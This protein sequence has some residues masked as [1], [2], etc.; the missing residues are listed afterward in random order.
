MVSCS[1][2]RKVRIRRK[3]K[4]LLMMFWNLLKKFLNR[5]LL[6]SR[7]CLLNSPSELKLR[8]LSRKPM[9]LPL[10]LRK[11]LHP[12]SRKNLKRLVKRKKK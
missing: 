5:R 2:G 1:R 3:R 10:A 9:V 7:N 8:N 6:L 4:R 11:A 12:A